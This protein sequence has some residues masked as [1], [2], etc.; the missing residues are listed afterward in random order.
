[1]DGDEDGGDD[2]G[3]DDDGDG[4]VGVGGGAGG[5]VGGGG[6]GDVGAGVDDDGDVDV[7]VDVD[8]DGAALPCIIRKDH[9][10]PIAYSSR[11]VAAFTDHICPA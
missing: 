9:A 2:A 1:V 8:V 3:V 5:D 4:D 6:G 7:D 11:H 10:S